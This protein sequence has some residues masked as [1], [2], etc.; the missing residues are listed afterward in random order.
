MSVFI[1]VYEQLCPDDKIHADDPR[2]GDIIAEMRAV[3]LARS[4]SEAVKVVE[5]WRAWSNPQHESAPAFVREARELMAGTRQL[6]PAS[7][8]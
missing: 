5:W 7:R 3:K 6:P 1:N 8:S 2:R 4:E